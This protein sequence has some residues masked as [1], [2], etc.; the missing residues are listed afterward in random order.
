MSNFRFLRKNGKIHGPFAPDRIDRLFSDGKLEPSDELAVHKE[1]PWQSI[2]TIRALI[3]RRKAEKTNH[4]ESIAVDVLPTSQP[5]VSDLP[6]PPASKAGFPHILSP[7]APA[8]NRPM[9]KPAPAYGDEPSNRAHANAEH[10]RSSVFY[11]FAP[12]RA[13]DGGVRYGSLKKYLS[14]SKFLISF[15]F[16]LLAYVPLVFLLLTVPLSML[17]ALS[18]SSGDGATGLAVG[19]LGAL[20]MFLGSAFTYLVWFGLCHLFYISSMAFVD[21]C[22]VI[23]DIEKNT[24]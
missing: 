19:G 15:L 16:G 22:R 14:I 4:A 10:L 18:A 3:E 17:G 7:P 21:F 13:E 2:T 23:V 8:G 24:R 6:D 9:A 12:W 20:V 5:D 11:W 1:G